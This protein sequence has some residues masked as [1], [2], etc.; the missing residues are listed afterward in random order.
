[1]E[2]AREEGRA[3]GRDAGR[4][5]FVLPVL[6]VVRDEREDG[7]VAGH[8]AEEALAQP[9][10]VV[11]AVDEERLGGRGARGVGRPLERGGRVGEAGPAGLEVGDERRDLPEAER[12]VRRRRDG[13][14]EAGKSAGSEPGLAQ[15]VR[16]PREER[17][18]RGTFTQVA[19]RGAGRVLAERAAGEERLAEGRHRGARV[20]PRGAFP[21]EVEEGD[22][23]EVGDAAER[24]GG[25]APQVDAEEVRA[26]EDVDRAE[27]VV[28]LERAD[29]VEEAL[30]E[31]AE[32]AREEGV[33][34]GCRHPA[35]CTAGEAGGE[36]LSPPSSAG[37]ARPRRRAGRGCAA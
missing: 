2:E 24:L 35:E 12:P 20:G 37:S 16:G 28:P 3:G 27:G 36:G 18:E 31:R 17:R 25:P 9:P 14:K 29:L 6:P 11:E 23:A 33:T 10:E 13:R 7:P 21:G 8:G 4:R 5:G 1:L 15:V 19:E 22:E 30:F 32:P 26:D 34:G